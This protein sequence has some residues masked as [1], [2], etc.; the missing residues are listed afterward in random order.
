MASSPTPNIN[1]TLG[2]KST[3]NEVHGDQTTTRLYS[4]KVR[5]HSLQHT[6]FSLNLAVQIIRQRLS[7]LEAL[8]P[9]AREELTDISHCLA[10]VAVSV[11]RQQASPEELRRDIQQQVRT[12]I[13][14][15]EQ[16]MYVYVFY[17]PIPHSFKVLEKDLIS[18]NMLTEKA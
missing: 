9:G 4:V 7:F 10:D 5:K 1:L 12:A 14:L 16:L 8:P 3:Y 17:P 2:P 18:I 6:Q 15:N 11:L 13:E